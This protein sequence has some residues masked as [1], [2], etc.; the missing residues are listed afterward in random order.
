AR[1][2]CAGGKGQSD[3]GAAI[4]PDDGWSGA[5]SVCGALLDFSAPEA[6]RSASVGA[7]TSGFFSS[8]VLDV[9]AAL[10][11]GLAS[12]IFFRKLSGR[13]SVQ[14]LLIYCRHSAWSPVLPVSR[15]CGAFARWAGQIE[16]CSSWFTTTL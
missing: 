14:K 12:A 5:P 13:M 11:W 2:R 9:H 8:M 7:P 4:R 3:S 15:Q 1:S 10:F 16:Y 6:A